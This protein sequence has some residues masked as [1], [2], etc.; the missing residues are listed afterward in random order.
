MEIAT[1][2]DMDVTRMTEMNPV[3]KAEKMRT[4][5]FN[6]TE[7]QIDI[8]TTMSGTGSPLQAL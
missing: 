8:Q 3:G 1:V 2:K 4:A 7:N 5:I 6:Q